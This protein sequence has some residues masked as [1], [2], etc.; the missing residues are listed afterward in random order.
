MFPQL[1]AHVSIRAMILPE[2]LCFCTSFSPEM[3]C[4][5]SFSF[6]LQTPLL[7]TDD[8]VHLWSML[9]G[10]LLHLHLK[11]NIYCLNPVCC[12]TEQAEIPW[13]QVTGSSLFK[14]LIGSLFSKYCKM[15]IYCMKRK[16]YICTESYWQTV[17]PKAGKTVGENNLSD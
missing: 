11:K 3:N 16:K 14:T 9:H 1:G 13:L 17:G 7:F 6:F 8:Q 4:D 15:S 2:F 12:V 5:C 10:S